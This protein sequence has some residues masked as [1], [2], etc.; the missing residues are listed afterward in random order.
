[1]TTIFLNKKINNNKFSKIIHYNNLYY[2]FGID[3]I[4]LEENL[5][6]YVI[7]YENYDNNFDFIEKQYIDYNFKESTLIRDISSDN[8]NFIFIIEQKSVDLNKHQTKCFKYYIKKEHIELF[9]ISKIEKLDLENYLISKIF[10]NITLS[11]KIEVDEER[12]DY[13]WGK[14][15]FHFMDE[16]KQFYRPSFDNIIDYSKDK[17]HLIHYIEENFDVSEVKWDFDN[18]G[19]IVLKKYFII[20]SI[21]HKY[22]NDPTKYYYKIYSSHTDDFKYFYDTKEIIIHNDLTDSKW[23]CYP[24]VFKKDG[25]YYVLVNQD[26]FGKEKESL[27]GEIVI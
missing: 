14:Y 21:R 22:E 16:N 23:Y 3:S 12:P 2:I 6:K 15:L 9:Q 5:N 18:D 26:D 19:N 27:L 4:R 13:Y 1:M 10:K 24:E 17:G 11:S 8:D 20:F 7:F 25:K